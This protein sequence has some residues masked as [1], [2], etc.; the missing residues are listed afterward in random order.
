[1]WSLRPQPPS[2][3]QCL[4]QTLRP[5]FALMRMLGQP[6]IRHLPLPL[7]CFFRGGDCDSPWESS[8]VWSGVP[9]LPYAV[10]KKK[11]LLAPPTHC[12]NVSYENGQ[13]N[14]TNT[15]TNHPF[16][17]VSIVVSLANKPFEDSMASAACDDPL[18]VR[19]VGH[20]GGYNTA[21]QLRGQEQRETM[22]NGKTKISGERGNKG[23]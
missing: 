13:K 8:G 23:R 17:L 14:K 10:R 6:R 2:P 20:N 15:Y 18:W 1:M 4:A 22:M 7:R 21:E 3:R 12:T 19:S 5:H 9:F 16:T 11:H